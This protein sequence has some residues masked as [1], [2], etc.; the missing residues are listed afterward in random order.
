L[1]FDNTIPH[2][3]YLSNL[4]ISIIISK[5]KFKQKIFDVVIDFINIYIGST[6]YIYYHNYDKFYTI[7]L[8]LKPY[9]KYLYSHKLIFLAVLNVFY[10]KKLCLFILFKNMLFEKIFYT[11]VIKSIPVIHLNQLIYFHYPSNKQ[12]LA[13]HYSLIPAF[14]EAYLIC[15]L[16]IICW[17]AK[18]HIS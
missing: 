9:L 13:L 10:S 14:W 7:L 15:F 5:S 4:I 17:V 2:D 12:V 18:V 1:L 11:K 16:S 8:L 6:R 3:S